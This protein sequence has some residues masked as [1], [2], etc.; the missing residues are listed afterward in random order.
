MSLTDT[1]RILSEQV[2]AN[3]TDTTA[4]LVLAD[5]LDEAGE[6][7]HLA[8]THRN[9][10]AAQA[11]VEQMFREQID[12]GSYVPETVMDARGCL[13]IAAVIACHLGGFAWVD[14]RELIVGLQSIPYVG[15]ANVSDSQRRKRDRF[16]TAIKDAGGDASNTTGWLYWAKIIGHKCV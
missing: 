2:A 5:A 10:A 8:K 11:A 7:A 4:R 15:H 6:P 3:P 16:A 13:S 9:L 1:V 12:A 14:R